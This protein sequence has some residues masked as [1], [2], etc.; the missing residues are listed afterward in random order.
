MIHVRNL[1]KFHP[2]YKDRDLIWCKSYF[3]MINTDP[4]FEMLCE[5]DKWRFIAFIMVELQ[6]KKPIPDDPAYWKRKGFDLKR[7][8]LT[9]TLAKLGENGLNM[10]EVVDSHNVTRIKESVLHESDEPCNVEKRREEKNKRREEKKKSVPPH[11]LLRKWLN[12]NW[13]TFALKADAHNYDRA[14]VARE[15]DKA[16]D[17]LMDNP[18]REYKS[19]ERFLLN[20]LRRADEIMKARGVAQ[21]MCEPTTMEESRAIYAELGRK[22]A[23]VVYHGMTANEEKSYERSKSRSGPC[24]NPIAISEVIES[25]AKE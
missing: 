17:W 7:R 20:W 12:E 21:G 5:V 8:P 18:N 15:C 22:K 1:E 16:I 6:T 13:T 11:L 14:R 24:G 10:I 19:H 3:R 23:G 4:E 25:I 9:K 2:G